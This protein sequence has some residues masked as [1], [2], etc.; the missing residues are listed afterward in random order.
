[1]PTIQKRNSRYRALVRRNGTTTSKTFRTKAEAQQ[2][3][4]SIETQLDVGTYTPTPKI[5]FSAVLDRYQ[6]EI[7][8]TKRSIKQTRSAIKRVTSDLGHLQLSAVTPAVLSQYRNRRLQQV[9]AQTVRKELNL[10]QRV[11]NACLLD[12]GMP[13]PNNPVTQIRMPRQPPGRDR[14]LQPGELDNLMAHLSPT[15]RR[16]VVF[17]I[18][19]GMRRGE[20]ASIQVNDIN[21]AKRTLRIRET[22]TGVP[23]TIPLSRKALEVI[24]DGFKIAPDSITH[25]LQRACKKAHIEDLRFHDLRHEAT[26]RLFEKGL[27]V[28]EVATITGHRDLKMLNRYTHLRAEDLVEKLDL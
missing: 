11:F 20:I 10:I 3:A 27:T 1:M 16:I 2:W 26:S 28:V 5:T 13:L 9:D 14:R 25:A 7:L 21:L 8:P 4:R 23:R 15:M 18:E 6:S 22:K 12:W 17:A 24:E 19:T